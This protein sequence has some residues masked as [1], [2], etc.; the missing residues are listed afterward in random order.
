MIG[1]QTSLGSWLDGPTATLI[2]G[3]TIA[4]AALGLGLSWRRKGF[5]FPSEPGHG[6]LG[7]HTVTVASCLALMALTALQMRVQPS[8]TILSRTS[9][10]TLEIVVG[11]WQLVLHAGLLA[12]YVW[13]FRRLADGRRWR[14]FFLCAIAHLSLIVCHD[15]AIKSVDARLLPQSG[16]AAF[17]STI[18]MLL[19]YASP[20]LTHAVLLVVAYQ[21][22][23]TST[24]RHWT[25]WLGVLVML[26]IEAV[27]RL[28]PAV[29][30][31]M[32]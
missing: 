28:Y 21:D 5:P 24:P 6:L 3:Q 10:S 1:D 15:A 22:W 29:L 32:S 27:A 16:G 13:C 4:A 12:V 8:D 11:W 7:V 20:F 2:V 23:R 17:I 26:V 9:L 31:L 30:W 19:D 14:L 25:H 18:R